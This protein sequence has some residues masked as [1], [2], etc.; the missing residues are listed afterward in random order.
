[1]VLWLAISKSFHSHRFLL[2]LA[3]IDVLIHSF[4]KGFAIAFGFDFVG[5]V[6][7]GYEFG[8]VVATDFVGVHFL[9]YSEV[10]IE[11]GYFTLHF[12]IINGFNWKI[13][14]I[15]IERK[16]LGVKVSSVLKVLIGLTS[17]IISI[18]VGIV[19]AV[20]FDVR[21]EGTMKVVLRDPDASTSSVDIVHFV[22]IEIGVGDI[23][24]GLFVDIGSN[25]A[26]GAPVILVGDT[27]GDNGLNECFTIDSLV[28]SEV[29]DVGLRVSFTGFDFSIH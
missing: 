12:F 17:R 10:S 5:V 11:S 9:L 21:S 16:N 20:H 13:I 6:L 15:F 25:G 29:L 18:R 22:E 1:M 27:R 7:C 8:V 4:H 19:Y 28:D 14:F 23:S 24:V 2:V 3:C 26:V